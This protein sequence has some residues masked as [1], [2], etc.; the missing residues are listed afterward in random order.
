M[1]VPMKKVLLFALAEE[2]D[3][4]LEALR[5]LGVMQVELSELVDN[6]VAGVGAALE[7]YDNVERFSQQVNHPAFSFIAPVDSDDRCAGHRSISFR[8][9]SRF[10]FIRAD[11]VKK[12]PLRVY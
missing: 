1:I 2:R 5:D 3:A 6:D 12:A 7:T 4:A 9:C 8:V 11:I 10:V